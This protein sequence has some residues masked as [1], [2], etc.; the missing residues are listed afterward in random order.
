MQI[1]RFLCA[2][3]LALMATSVQ[4]KGNDP[5]WVL[6]TMDYDGNNTTFI[7]QANLNNP[8]AKVVLV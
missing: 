2:A 8:T 1:V 7:D 5:E 3:L 6:V 4:A